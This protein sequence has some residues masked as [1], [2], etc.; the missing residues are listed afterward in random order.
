MKGLIKFGMPAVAV[1]TLVLFFAFPQTQSVP[2]TER[3]TPIRIA[4]ST[5]PL[6][7]PFYVAEQRGYFREAGIDVEIIDIAG[8]GK[9]FKALQEGKA[10]LATVSNSVIMFNSF[11]HDN[12]SVLTSFVESDNDIKLLTLEKS[13]IKQ[14]NDFNL[15]KV[16]VVKG[17]A[18]EYF[19]HT[20]LTLGGINPENVEYVPLSVN[21]MPE[22][23]HS[24]KV[25]AISV[26]E[27][28]AFKA[29]QNQESTA[30][31]IE[32]KG[33]YNL[34]F[35]L[36]GKKESSAELNEQKKHVL[37]ALNKAVHYISRHPQKSQLI[38]RHRLKLSKDFIDWIW[39]DYLFK[40]SLSQSLLVS[41][42]QQAY[43]A[44]ESGLIKTDTAPNF[45]SLL[46]PSILK[47][48][49]HRATSL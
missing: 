22:A 9:C 26:R 15:R 6:S 24:E 30:H 46:D 8:G 48:I 41:L 17:S 29:T 39:Q 11:K 4:V 28:F 44:I 47:S 3:Q 10:D 16:G 49:D 34:S 36:A 1:I 35:N 33:L 40:L 32:T 25:D 43:W 5:T 21:E 14:V 23:L 37:A 45:A 2:K 31:L 18:S 19:F 38:L 42:E 20:W 13:Q 27:P 12:F 7:A